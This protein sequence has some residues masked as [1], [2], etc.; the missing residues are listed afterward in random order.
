KAATAAIRSTTVPS[1]SAGITQALQQQRALADSW[2]VP[3]I[4][5]ALTAYL[6]QNKAAT[7]AIRSTVT[8]PR[9]AD[10]LIRAAFEVLD[11]VNAANDDLDLEQAVQ[12]AVERAKTPLLQTGA[13]REIIN[14][15]LLFF[16]VAVVVGAP[17][18]N[19]VLGGA[20]VAYLNE[21]GINHKFLRDAVQRQI[22]KRW[23]IE[24][25]EE[26]SP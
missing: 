1:I 8:I 26:K 9:Y 13:A 7:A 23:P 19:P 24:G 10:E 11:E 22:D 21:K 12:S 25:A 15:V 5:S 3:T 6:E 16:M 20:L 4:Q 14:L 17:M 18:M 2:K